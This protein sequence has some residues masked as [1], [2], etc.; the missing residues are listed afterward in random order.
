VTTAKVYIPVAIG[1]EGFDGSTASNMLRFFLGGL[2]CVLIVNA[3]MELIQPL[4]FRSQ[5]D[6]LNTESKDWSMTNPLL[7]SG[8]LFP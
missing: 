6:P 4:P 1:H 2:L 5:Y 3:H 7:A 8:M